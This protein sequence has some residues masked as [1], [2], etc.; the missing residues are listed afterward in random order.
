MIR[1]LLCCTVCL[2]AAGCQS[3]GRN[4]G[5]KVLIG[6]TAI[7]GPGAAPVE[8]YVIVV[9]GDTIRSAGL[10]K[11][12]PMPQDSERTDLSG[13]WIVAAGN[14]RIAA[15]QPADLVI[16]NAAPNGGVPAVD[17]PISRRLIRG[18]WN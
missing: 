1:I 15:G 8:D 14:G 10:R 13:K 6:A 7:T 3:G 17:V 9:S 4:S 11:D 12:I 16:F 5:I 18:Q 2:L